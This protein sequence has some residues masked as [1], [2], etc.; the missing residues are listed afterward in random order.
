MAWIIINIHVIKVNS[1]FM[2]ADT[3]TMEL[4]SS[5][6]T[7]WWSCPFPPSSFFQHLNVVFV[8]IFYT[9][10]VTALVRLVQSNWRPCAA[11][12]A[13]LNVVFVW[14]FYIAGVTVLVRLVPSGWRPYDVRP[15]W[16]LTLTGRPV[17]GRPR[18]PPATNCPVSS[19]AK[20]INKPQTT[21]RYNQKII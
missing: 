1:V 7:F 17:T 4:Y 11:R 21:S 15:V 5:L 3:A 10:G 16:P 9:A 18:S 19:Y 20:P 6:Y 14:I 8:W 2:H 12:P 13:S